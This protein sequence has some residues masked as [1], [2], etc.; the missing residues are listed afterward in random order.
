MSTLTVI[1]GGKHSQPYQKLLAH[2]RRI[3]D[4]NTVLTGAVEEREQQLHTALIRGCQDAMAIAELR[5]ENEAIKEANAELRRTT[6]RAKAE[7]ERLRRAVIN[8]RPRIREVPTD[9]VRPYSPTVVL[10]YVSPV[11]HRD[12]SNDE[13]QEIALIDVPQPWPTYPAA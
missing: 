6:I 13:T 7:Q 1:A 8:A 11:P 5:A 3:E 10:P 2:T 12:T 9:L 4:D